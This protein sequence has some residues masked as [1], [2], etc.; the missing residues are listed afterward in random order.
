MA[1][2][3]LKEENKIVIVENNIQHE[4]EVFTL[5]DNEP[6]FRQNGYEVDGITKKSFALAFDSANSEYL[7]DTT[8]TGT[9]TNTDDID[10]DVDFSVNDWSGASGVQGIVAIGSSTN[11][12]YVSKWVS[13]S[14]FGQVLELNSL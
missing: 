6:I 7:E 5:N 10:V 9:I 1:V 14:K 12:F 13:M 4:Q 3:N 11:Y 8:Q 2:I